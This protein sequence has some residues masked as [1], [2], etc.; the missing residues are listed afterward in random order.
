MRVKRP[1]EVLEDAVW[2]LRNQISAVANQSER[3][4]LLGTVVSVS[5]VSAVVGYVLTQYYSVDVL[6]SL[7][8]NPEDCI[9]NWVPHIGSHCFSDYNLPV[10]WGMR[11]NPWAP[12][13]LFWPPDYQPAHPNYPAASMLPQLIFGLLANWL[14]AP[15]L[16]LLG[17]LLALTIAVL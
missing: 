9:L 4:L 6:S 10:S 15:Q 14:S 13:P 1:I 2:A 5:A 17:Y 8:S 16:G 7:V 3:T 11:P 12:Y